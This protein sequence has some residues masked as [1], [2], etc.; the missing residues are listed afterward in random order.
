MQEDVLEREILL[1]IARKE[2][3][4]KSELLEFLK[5]K[6]DNPLNVLENAIKNLNTNGLIQ[7]VSPLGE[8]SYI[9]TQKGIREVERTK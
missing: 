4:T 3:I 6:T 2:V 5:A 7:Y 8:S 1:E 9:I